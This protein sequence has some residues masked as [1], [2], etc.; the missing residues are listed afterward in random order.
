MSTPIYPMAMIPRMNTSIELYYLAFPAEWK[1]LILRMHLTIDPKF[2]TLY[3]LKTNVLYG[4]L[5]GW[6]EDVVQIHSMKQDSDDSRWMVSLQEP[7]VVH[8]C[9]ILEIWITAEYLQHKNRTAETERLA[10]E[11]IAMLSPDVLRAGMHSEEV[12]L[13]D[14]QGH[15]LTEDAFGA[16]AL[17]AANTLCGK[18]VTLSGHELTLSACGTKMLMSQPISDGKKEPHYYAIGFQLSVQTTPP[19]RTCMLLVD[20]SAKRFISN[21]WKEDIYLKEDLHA[22]VSVGQN[23]YRRITLKHYPHA[24]SKPEQDCYDLYHLNP[25]PDAQEVLHH[26]EQHLT[27]SAE[28]RILLPYKFGM[29][30][31][32]MRIGTG[33]SVK[34]KCELF[35][36]IVSLLQDFAEPASRADPISMGKIAHPVKKMKQEEA[37]RHHRERLKACT[38]RERLTVEIYGHASDTALCDRIKT[39]FADYLGDAQYQAIFP[40]QIIT[41]ELGALGDMMQDDSYAAHCKRIEAVKQ[42]IGKSAEIIGAIVILRDTRDQ[43]GDPKHAL[44]AGFVD[45]N[46]LT[47]FI[48]PDAEENAPEHR[49]QGAVM[50]LLRQ[51]GYTEFEET[52]NTQRNPAFAADAVGISI[53]HQLR[54]LRADRS[55]SSRDTARHLPVYVTYQARSGRLSVDCDLFA[56]RHMSYPEALLAF[57]K[58][59]REPEFV[60][61]CVDAA[62]GGIRTKLLGLQS[63]YREQPVLILMQANGVTR[64]LWHGLTDKK[65]AEYEIS[66]QYVPE[67]IEIGTKNFSDMRSFLGTGVRILRIR[68]NHSTH[69]VPDYYTGQNDKGNCVTASG[70]FRYKDVFWGLESRPF[71]KEYSMSYICSRLTDSSRSFDECSLIEYYPVQL[72]EGD[73]AEQWCA[74]ANALREVMPESSRSV[75]LPA[76]LHFAELMEEYLLLTTHRK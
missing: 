65:I 45:T 24:W 11:L 15:A 43:E 47:Q 2:N 48:T 46:R 30:F 58:L 4:Y 38:G 16:F 27:D 60:Q 57:S 61:K 53:L 8:I 52:R 56:Q 10:E 7:D 66:R 25:L 3:N 50:D 42:Q 63:L 37:W 73:D 20:A 12:I 75:R 26:P 34:D 23:K 59:S 17:Y 55:R 32:N 22:F 68:E 76:P 9:E 40:V 69:E 64:P 29:G 1:R 51:F 19:A 14:T 35:P 70:V 41:R 44:R 6:L 49:I 67:K 13:F 31:T 21:A 18:T 54:P 71:N 33:I 62:R 28:P 74:Y 72:Q 39:A 36:Q 5:N